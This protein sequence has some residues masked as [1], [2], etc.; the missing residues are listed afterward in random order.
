MSKRTEENVKDLTNRKGYFKVE[1]I[2]SPQKIESAR[3]TNFNDALKYGK[4]KAKLSKYDD[5]YLLA[6]HGTDE[7]GED[8][9]IGQWYIT[10]IGGLYN[11][12]FRAGD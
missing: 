5:A 12:E 6:F 9:V 7:E 1:W 8:K 3:F 4:S 2:E 11:V 10:H